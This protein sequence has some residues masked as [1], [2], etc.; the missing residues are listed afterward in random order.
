VRIRREEG[1]SDADFRTFW[2][3]K[4]LEFFEIYGVSATT[5][6]VKCGQKGR[7]SIFCDF[8]RTSFMDGP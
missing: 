4:N 7:G 1:F 6:V 5:R 8:V 2:F 3:Q